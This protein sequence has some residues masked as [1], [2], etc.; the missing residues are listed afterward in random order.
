MFVGMMIILVTLFGGTSEK[1]YY[2]WK[3]VCCPSDTS[4]GK[5][6]KCIHKTMYTGTLVRVSLYAEISSRG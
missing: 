5:I 1:E 3:Y 4:K 6:Y 2:T